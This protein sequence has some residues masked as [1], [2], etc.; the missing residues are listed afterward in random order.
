MLS[1][2]ILRTMLLVTLTVLR[3][4]STRYSIC[5]A[6]DKQNAFVTIL[7]L[8]KNVYGSSS[9]N[10]QKT[11]RDTAQLLRYYELEAH[12]SDLGSSVYEPKY[13]L[14]LSFRTHCKI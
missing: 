7:G 1:L 8:R 13:R 4:A 3:G 12:I 11:C 6:Y 10:L 14:S 5:I 9:L 2:G